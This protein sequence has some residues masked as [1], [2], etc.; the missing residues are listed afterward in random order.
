MGG[1]YLHA[2]YFPKTLIKCSK[3][4]PACTLLDSE[5]S[6]LLAVLVV[7]T[8]LVVLGMCCLPV[9]IFFLHVSCVQGQTDRIVFQCNGRKV[10]SINYYKTGT[11]PRSLEYK[12]AGTNTDIVGNLEHDLV[13]EGGECYNL[14]IDG[15]QVNGSHT[16][17]INITGY[18]TPKI[19]QP[20]WS[21]LHLC[22]DIA[23]ER[24]ITYDRREPYQYREGEVDFTG[25]SMKGQDKVLEECYHR[26]GKN[27]VIKDKLRQNNKCILKLG[28]YAHNPLKEWLQVK[29]NETNYPVLTM[30]SHSLIADWG[31]AHEFNCKNERH[32]SL[33]I[34]MQ[35]QDKDMV[36]ESNRKEKKLERTEFTKFDKTRDIDFKC[37]SWKITMSLDIEMLEYEGNL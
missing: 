11:E 16:E 31:R 2:A 10:T 6:S 1:P 35:R 33:S 32:H 13:V 27:T 9:M 30:K 8:V 25:Y 17:M 19:L 3:P 29:S 36:M 34:K 28:T 21:G 5:V 18:Q 12:C 14:V 4:P 37:F 7:L 24:Y 22:Q 23:M 26:I 20:D 15:I